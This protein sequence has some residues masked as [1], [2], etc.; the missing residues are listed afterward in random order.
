[1]KSRQPS[2]GSIIVQL[3]IVALVASAGCG[4]L[5]ALAWTFLTLAL[6]QIAVV[7]GWGDW[8]PWSLPALFSGMTGPPGEALGGHSYLLALIV[9]LAG[10]GGVYLWMV[11]ADQGR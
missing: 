2:G 6:S 3:A 10:V 9:F 11:Y 4:Y 5:P 1:M 8:F 7:L